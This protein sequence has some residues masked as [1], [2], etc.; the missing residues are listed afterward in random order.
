MVRETRIRLGAF[1]RKR[2]EITNCTDA[3]AVR[4]EAKMREIASDMVDAG[5]AADAVP[6]LKRMGAATDAEQFRGAVRLAE[7]LCSG[8]IGK[9]KASGA[10][11]T[12]RM[13]GEEWTSGRLHRRFP[14]HVRDKDHDADAARLA[15]LCAV[16]VGGGTLGD[17]PIG[18]FVV[19]HA[20][21]AMAGLPESAKR[22]STRRHY[23]QVL[24]RALALAVY[25][26]RL[27]AANPLPRG[28]MPKVGKSP[29]HGYLY[30][31]EDAKLLACSTVPLE[32]RVLFGFLAREGV[33]L[34]EALSLRWRDLDLERGVVKLD[35]NKTDDPRAWALDAGVVAALVAWK[36]RRG[37][38]AQP[39]AAVFVDTNGG[40][41]ESTRLA[42]RFRAALLLA[43][44]DRA[45]LHVSTEARARIR[46]HDLRG[47][48]VTL[49]LANGKS[50]TWVADRT[51]HR[52]SIMINRYR[53]QAR[54]ASETALGALAPLVEAVP[55]FA[56][57]TPKPPQ[58]GPTGGPE[59]DKAPWRN[60]R[61]RGFKIPS[62]KWRPGSTPGG[63]TAVP[64]FVH[65]AGRIA[66]CAHPT[67]R[68]MSPFTDVF[69]AAAS[70]SSRFQRATGRRTERTAVGSPGGRP[71][72]TTGPTMH[73][74]ISQSDHSAMPS[75]GS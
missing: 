64:R 57:A 32:E 66:R 23:A 58:G 67:L 44:V 29:A 70:F 30:P 39:D 9:P 55:E 60:G 51:G 71:R 38:A 50:E 43:G 7:G 18:S 49:A 25:P 42:V 41:F 31:D 26:L 34:G 22:P 21:A 2:F 1:G 16:D 10:S 54:Q 11:M 53:R 56:R 47:T 40:A 3:E 27:I 6:I 20:E 61:R 15:K 4:R 59:I 37:D 69:F 74:G 65:P 62:Q 5:L 46:V 72:R 52:S 36:A 75:D 73:D 33:R 13:L 24:H 63:A 35:G 28:F 19:D 45:E 68:R 8:R 48:F 12:F 17:V 14:D